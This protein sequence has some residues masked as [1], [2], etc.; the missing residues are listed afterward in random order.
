MSGRVL[1]SRRKRGDDFGTRRVPENLGASDL[2]PC[3][4]L[5]P[6]VGPVQGRGPFKEPVC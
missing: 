2:K 6:H 1:D 3:T 5:E 4:S